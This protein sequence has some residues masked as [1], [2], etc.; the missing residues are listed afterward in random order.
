MSEPVVETAAALLA[1]GASPED[2]IV[3]VGECPTMSPVTLAKIVAVRCLP[4]D[5]RQPPQNG[6]WI[7]SYSR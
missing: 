5:Y 6:R 4:T 7:A 2:E 1:A 3:A